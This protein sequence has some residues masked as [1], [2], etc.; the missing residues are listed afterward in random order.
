MDLFLITSYAQSNVMQAKSFY[1]QRLRVILIHDK[2]CIKIMDNLLKLWRMVLENRR[3]YDKGLCRL[4]R[5]KEG[6]GC[7][8]S[9]LCSRVMTCKEHI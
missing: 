2:I 1:W 3:S 7:T 6:N 5:S 9:N 8:L 4:P